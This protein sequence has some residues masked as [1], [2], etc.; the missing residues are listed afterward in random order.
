VKSHVR[1]QLAGSGVL[2]ETTRAKEL[3]ELVGHLEDTVLEMLQ[4]RREQAD[5]PVLVSLVQIEAGS[6]R[7][8]LAVSR[9]ALAALS[10]VTQAVG[11]SAFD[12]LPPTVHAHLY[13]ISGQAIRNRWA[14][15]FLGAP[16]IGFAPGEISD[17]R[18]VPPPPTP[19]TAEGS[20]SVY[21]RCLRVGGVHPRAEVRL[22]SG[23]LLYVDVDEALAKQLARSLYEEVRLDGHARWDSSNWTLLAFRVDRVAPVVTSDPEAAFTLLARSAGRRWSGVNAHDYLRRVRYGERK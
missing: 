12:S 23:D 19:A 9:A 11:T 17:D 16:D 15:Q 22:L 20:T 13:A 10:T 18:P 4:A 8:T 6:N 21:G 7:L 14:V 2:P 1:I 3:A 5:D